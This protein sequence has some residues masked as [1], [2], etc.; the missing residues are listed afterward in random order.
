MMAAMMLP[1]TAPAVAKPVCGGVGAQNNQLG[2]GLNGK[3]I[4]QFSEQNG[5]SARVLVARRCHPA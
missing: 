5:G 3:V 4:T 1:G 2:T